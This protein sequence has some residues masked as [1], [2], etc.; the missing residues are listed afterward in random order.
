MQWVVRRCT[1]S[2]VIAAYL[3]STPHSSGFVRLAYEAFYEA[4]RCLYF[5][6]GYHGLDAGHKGR[7][8]ALPRLAISP[9]TPAT[10]PSASVS[11]SGLLPPAWAMS[12]R[13]PP[14]PSTK[15]A[16]S[17][18]ISRASN[19]EVRSLVTITTMAALS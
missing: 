6:R 4:V 19:R 13:P 18:M 11:P 14:R 10:L 1:A 2:F 16:I 9:T 7:R 15:G 8:Y 3:K 12:G 5:L 17:L